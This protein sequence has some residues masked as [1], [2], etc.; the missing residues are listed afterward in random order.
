MRFH[1]HKSNKTKST[2]LSSVLS[3]QICSIQCSEQ[4]H[5]LGFVEGLLFFDLL[6][7]LTIGMP[8]NTDC[9]GAR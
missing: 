9:F 1:L 5:M 7:H 8:K 2:S 6:L 4:A 3:T